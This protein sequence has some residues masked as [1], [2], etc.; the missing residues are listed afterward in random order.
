MEKIVSYRKVTYLAMFVQFV[1]FLEFVMINP[2]SPDYIVELGIISSDVG[3]IL[4]AYAFSACFFGIFASSFIDKYD[5][6]KVLLICFTGMA[7]GSLV[8]ILSTNFTMLIISRIIAGGFG[9]PATAITFA[10]MS[11]FVPEAKRGKAFGK[12]MSAFPLA[13]IVGIPLALEISR[14]SSW[15]MAYVMVLLFEIAILIAVY[16]ILP[17]VTS[18]VTKESLSVTKLKK[19]YHLLNNK[20][21]VL[22][23]SS[24]FLT[25]FSFFLIVP[26]IPPYFIFNLDFPR[27]KLALLFFI[28]GSLSFF[29]VRLIGKL[30]DKYDSFFIVSVITMLFIPSIVLGYGQEAI[31]IP[32]LLIFISFMLCVT[33]RNAILVIATSRLPSPQDRAGYMALQNAIQNFATGMGGFIS[34]VLLTEGDHL[35][36]VGLT[37][38]TL[39]TVVASLIIPFLVKAFEKKIS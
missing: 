28:G 10:I 32:P 3:M 1:N 14:I 15:Q 38:V 30:S 4:G 6:K 33:A 18:H 27:E 5:R 26:V 8:C 31:K 35:Q 37:K 19:M 36:V 12:I 34:G 7:I 39:L 23:I 25:F 20:E 29:V 13:S 16:R 17:S 21:Y 24:F 2:L 9:G 22:G 11:D